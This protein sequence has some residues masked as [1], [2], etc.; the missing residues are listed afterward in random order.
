MN[1]RVK[2]PQLLDSAASR[3]EV[4]RGRC[5]GI[6]I[7]ESMAPDRFEVQDDGSLGIRDAIVP[8][9]TP[10]QVVA[11]VEGCPAESLRIVRPH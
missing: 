4:D 9:D 3:I 8:E 7:C 5:T 10:A 2:E 1:Q 11:A 6:G